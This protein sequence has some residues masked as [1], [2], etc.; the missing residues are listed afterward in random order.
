MQI[1]V[2]SYGHGTAPV[3]AMQ[4][5]KGANVPSNSAKDRALVTLLLPQSLKTRM[6]RAW[7]LAG[8][9]GTLVLFAD[10]IAVVGAVPV[11]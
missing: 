9:L 3:T 6:T 8:L 10:C 5:A 11:P 4:P 2:P 7:S 1:R